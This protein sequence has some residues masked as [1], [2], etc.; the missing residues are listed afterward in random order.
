[1][2]HVLRVRHVVPSHSIGEVRDV[3]ERC[4]DLGMV[5]GEVTASTRPRTTNGRFVKHVSGE[6]E[7]KKYRPVLK[8]NKCSPFR[9][10]RAVSSRDGWRLLQPAVYAFR[11][12]L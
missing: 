2:S 6:S 5:T 12:G 9:S 8:P 10:H 11:G 4:H 1:M 7:K 3:A